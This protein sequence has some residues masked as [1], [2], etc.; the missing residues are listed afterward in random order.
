MLASLNTLSQTVNLWTYSTL[1]VELPS[2]CR[3]IWAQLKDDTNPISGIERGFGI[4]PLG[5]DIVLANV[6]RI[7]TGGSLSR[8][9]SRH[10]T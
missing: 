5:T 7:N 1:V 9:G 10:W 6:L 8:V 4:L 2:I 3:L